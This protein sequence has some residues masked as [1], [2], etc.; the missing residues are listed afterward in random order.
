MTDSY[1]MKISRIIE[2]LQSLRKDSIELGKRIVSKTLMQND[3]YP[4]SLLNRNMFL[5]ECCLYC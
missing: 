2:Q 1:E 3:F 5:I 4:L